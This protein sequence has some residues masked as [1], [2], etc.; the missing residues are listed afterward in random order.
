MTR[1]ATLDVVSLASHIRVF[2]CI[3]L[4]REFCDCQGKT[5][6]SELEKLKE[7]QTQE[8]RPSHKLADCIRGANLL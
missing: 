7:R 8:R 3:L 2:F 6:N 4:L 5:K 1:S